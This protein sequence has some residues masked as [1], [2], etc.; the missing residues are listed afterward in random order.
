[1]RLDEF[2]VELGQASSRSQAKQLV[3]QGA[4]Q[5]NGKVVTKPAQKTNK[6]DE[7]ILI[8]PQ[9]YVGRGAKKISSAINHFQINPQDLVVA[10]IGACTG[11]FTDYLLQ[12]GASKIY[13]IDVGKGQ[14][15]SK[16]QND[17]RVVNMEGINIKNPLELP[18]KVDLAVVDLSFISLKLTLKNI[19]ALIKE[20]GE[21]IT[22]IKPQ[23]EAG[24]RNIPKDGVI[25]NK[26]MLKN[27]LQ[28]FRDWCH[29]NDFQI[30]QIIPSPITG[31]RGNKEYLAKITL[32]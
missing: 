2:L 19:A 11:G 16:L 5:L 22:L 14:L 28:D 1:M 17:P 29:K 27:I 25:K 3:Q 23:F 10:D 6:Q 20:N 7:V 26:E 31:K 9:Q 18:E 24:H 32:Q 12:E 15:A 4:V 8:N 13:A 21:I 30:S